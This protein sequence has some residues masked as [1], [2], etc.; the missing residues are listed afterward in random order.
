ME[1]QA[2]ETHAIMANLEEA[3]KGVAGKAESLEK[4]LAPALAALFQSAEASDL[5]M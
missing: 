5:G 1:G 3:L 2:P 4:R